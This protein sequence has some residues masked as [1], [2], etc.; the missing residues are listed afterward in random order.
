M[1]LRSPRSPA[2]SRREEPQGGVVEEGEERDLGEDEGRSI[3]LPMHV[4]PS[5]R[6]HAELGPRPTALETELGFR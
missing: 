4:G 1:R 3:D 5:S 2:A 6:I